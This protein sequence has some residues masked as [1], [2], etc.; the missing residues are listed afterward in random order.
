[1]AVKIEI[2]KSGT[3]PHYLYIASILELAEKSCNWSGYNRREC[4]TKIL[5]KH[6]TGTIYQVSK[7]LGCNKLKPVEM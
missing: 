3:L 5:I 6:L 7:N 2:L 4:Y 1:M